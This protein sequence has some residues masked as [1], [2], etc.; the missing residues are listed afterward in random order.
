[1]TLNLVIDT[2]SL[3]NYIN[4]YYFDKYNSKNIHYKLNNFLIQKI[5]SGE[6]IVIDK[7][8]IEWFENNKNKWLKSKIKTH[9]KDTIFLF[10]EVER[11]IKVNYRKDIETKFSLNQSQVESELKKY[12]EYYADLYLIAYC[13][14]L[15]KK[16]IDPILITEETATADKKLIEKIP[17][18][19][20][21]EKI[22]YRKIPYSLFEIYK[23]ELEFRDY[24]LKKSNYYQFAI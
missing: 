19:C 23:K 2:S 11:L 14:Y 20:K 22:E 3:I 5:Q 12:E 15:K 10:P 1:M 17:T 4:Y 24:Y 16:M 6:I 21:K 9:I 18:I 7:V 13:K 8:F